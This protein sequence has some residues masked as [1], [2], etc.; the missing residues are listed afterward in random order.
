MC[1]V[2][3]T[4]TRLGVTP[5]E[6]FLMAAAMCPAEVFPNVAYSEWQNGGRLATWSQ[7]FCEEAL[8]LPHETEMPH[9]RVGDAVIPMK[10]HGH[11]CRLCESC[12]HDCD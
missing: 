11:S 3:E 2:T 8:Q 5:N 12:R 4:A 1:L 10:T 9:F 7:F 6:V